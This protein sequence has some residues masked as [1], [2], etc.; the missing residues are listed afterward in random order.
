MDNKKVL[1]LKSELEGK[2]PEEILSICHNMFKDKI[3]FSTSL[4]AEDQALTKIISEVVPSMK[5]FTLDTGRLFAE[6]Y[7]LLD[8]TSKKYKIKIQ[9]YF[10]DY[11]E[12][13][14]MVNEKGINLF[15]ESIENRKQ[16]CNIRKIKPMQ[17]ALK[18][19]DA[20]ISG[21]RRGQSF[22][23]KDIDLVEWDENNNIIK[24]N[25]LYNWT[26]KMIWNYIDEYKIPY[27]P[28]HKKDYPSIGCQPCTREI[29]PGEDVRA[30][31]WWWENSYTRECGL[32]KKS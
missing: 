30:G 32:H 8:R 2:T 20:W 15:F 5:I 24:I 14:K 9:T 28:L 29:F 25:P 7:D 22:V 21:L 18:G 4:G 3:C 31:R 11:K 26:E 10:P 6:T 23:R 1:E 12:V 19:M 17:R 16:C 13:E 27:N